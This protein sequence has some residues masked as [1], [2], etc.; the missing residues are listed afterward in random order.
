MKDK[1]KEKLKKVIQFIANPRLL[2]CLGIAW[3]ITNG[4]SYIMFGFGTYYGIGWM[5][6]VSSA[7][8]TFLWL[9]ISP[10]KIATVAIAIMLLRLFFP[11]DKKTL[12]VLHQM[13]KKVKDA[14]KSKKK[15]KKNE[16]EDISS[17]KD[18]QK[19]RKDKK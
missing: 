11:K 17:K 6:A 12:A 5:I 18:I 15:A 1:T 10:E 14:V 3:I 8:L 19:K 2:V 7:Y 4:W 16:S 9:P 13:S